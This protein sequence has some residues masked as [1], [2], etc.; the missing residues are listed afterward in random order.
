VFS[1]IFSL[2]SVTSAV[3]AK[4]PVVFIDGMRMEF[5]VPPAIINGSTLVPLRAI[6]EELGAIIE[7]NAG[8][9]TVTAVKGD[10]TITYT[11]GETTAQRNQETLTLSTP[12]QIID[13]RTLVPLRFV[14]EALG[15]V[16]GWEPRS[17]TVTI[18][19]FAKTKTVVTRIIDG[20]TVEINVGGTIEKCA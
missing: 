20:D 3:T 4:A 17:R 12:G 6:F 5:E 1:L 8:T 2:S 13:S 10:I 16:V 15:A 18:S 9:R 19:S 11:I 14:S 7:W